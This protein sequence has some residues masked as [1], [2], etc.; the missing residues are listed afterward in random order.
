MCG[1]PTEK[2]RT[3]NTVK[4]RWNGNMQFA[5]WDARGHGIV[6][7]SVPES[8]GEGTGPRPIELLLYA[9]AG[10]TGMDV[11]GILRKQRQKLTGL[12]L[13][14]EGE[15]RDEHPKIYPLIRIEYVFTGFGLSESGIKRAIELSEEKYCPVRQMLGPQVQ[16]ETSYRI[17]EAEGPDAE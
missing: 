1:D 13:D 10:C 17:V 12:E 6:L 11:V 16:V 3:M 14:I 7:D 9:I 15:Q 5:G 8:N 4:L 2:G